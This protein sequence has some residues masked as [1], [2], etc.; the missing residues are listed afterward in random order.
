MKILVIDDSPIHQ[1]AARKQ[2]AAEHD[3]TVV[4][5]Y[6]EAQALVAE[7]HRFEVVLCDLLMP[8][9]G[10]MQAGF[11]LA[12]KEMPVGIFLA[13]LACKNGAKHV[14]LLTDSDHHSHPASACLDAFNE[15][16][17][18]PTA[19]AVAGSRLLLSNDRNW[20]EDDKS[21][22]PT[23]T[24]R[25]RI[26]GSKYTW[27]EYPRIKRWDWLLEYLIHPPTDSP[28]SGVA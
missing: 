27:E 6:D 23:V 4:G 20:I 7:P 13:L 16:E 5:S 21:V 26:D 12:G 24:E 19:F 10:Q 3:L 8:A 22:Q 18:R 1:N 25:T 28:M 15:A 9:S 11:D 2:L 17:S 14:G